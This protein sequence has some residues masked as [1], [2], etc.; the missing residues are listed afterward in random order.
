MA[1]IADG[2]HLLVV[3]THHGL[4]NL[5][6]LLLHLL[7]ELVVVSHRVR[8]E[9]RLRQLPLTVTSPDLSYR[10]TPNDIKVF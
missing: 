3:D 1:N 7:L 6:E 8:L 9:G 5:Q 2:C 10:G 4:S